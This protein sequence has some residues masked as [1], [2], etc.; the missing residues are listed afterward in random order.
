MYKHRQYVHIFN[1]VYNLPPF[2]WT[3]V[4]RFSSEDCWLK[5]P[6]PTYTPIPIKL[7]EIFDVQ[8]KV[9]TLLQLASPNIRDQTNLASIYKNGFLSVGYI[10]L[11]NESPASGYGV[12]LQLPT[13]DVGMIGC[14]KSI[15]LSH[16]YSGVDGTATSRNEYW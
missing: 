1:D 12:S 13:A 7:D 11:T 15:Y 9:N 3:F 10:S 2:D 14:N 16:T 8:W 4:V 6:S 5:G